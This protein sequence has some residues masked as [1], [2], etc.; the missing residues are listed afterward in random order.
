M[1]EAYTTASEARHKMN[2][3][4]AHISCEQKVADIIVREHE[5]HLQRRISEHKWSYTFTTYHY[6]LLQLIS[7]HY[8]SSDYNMAQKVI[9]EDIVNQISDIYRVRGFHC[10]RLLQYNEF[11]ASENQTTFT[12]SWKQKSEKR[13]CIIS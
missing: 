13:Q 1:T 3:T 7:A 10:Q 4:A 5:C 11:L 2:E 12:I 8:P 9:I 6:A